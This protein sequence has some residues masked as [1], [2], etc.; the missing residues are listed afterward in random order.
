VEEAD[1]LRIQSGGGGGVQSCGFGFPGLV[2][3][4]IPLAGLGGLR[5]PV[6]ISF[7]QVCLARNTMNERSC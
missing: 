4:L 3:G 2:E 6:G 1:S 7:V 5:H